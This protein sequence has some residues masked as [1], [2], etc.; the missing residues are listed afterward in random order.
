MTSKSQQQIFMQEALKEADLALQ[1]GEL[2]IGAI[3]VMGDEIIVRSSTK[4]KELKARI[5]HAE[6]LALLELDKMKHLNGK[7]REIHLYTNLE[8]C[9][10]CLGACLVSDISKVYYALE[11][12]TDGAAS[13]YNNWQKQPTNH[14][15]CRPIE[16]FGGDLR[17][18]SRDIFQNFCERFPTGGFSD[19]AKTLL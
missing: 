10:M 13:F 6:M 18:Q 2:P 4:D 9:I 14:A 8:P 1:R 16:I 11:S 3:L 12:S 19:W 7:R 17:E 15:G 5:V